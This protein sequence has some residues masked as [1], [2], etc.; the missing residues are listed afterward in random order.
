MTKLV[1]DAAHTEYLSEQQ[2]GVLATIGPGGAPQA[3]PVG[4]RY[5][6]E[7]GT[8]DIGGLELDVAELGRALDLS[9]SDAETYNRHFA[10]DV[11]WGSPYGATVADYDTL[12]AIHARMHASPDRSRSRYEIVRVLTPAPDLA[13]AQVRRD[14]LDND[15]HPIPSHAADARFS[16]MALYVLVR[17]NGMWWLA[18][19]QNTKINIDGGAVTQ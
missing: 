1:F 11:M 18:A 4:F 8:I 6:P 13:L 15:G 17:R 12:H 5:D 7:R 19:G 2:H 10:D 14:E 3:K 9:D 16:E